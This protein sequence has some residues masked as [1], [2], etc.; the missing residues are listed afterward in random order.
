MS[1]EKTRDNY[2]T[3][4]FCDEC[5]EKMNVVSGD[6]PILSTDEYDLSWGDTCSNCGKTLEEE[7]KENKS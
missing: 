3:D 5:Y 1:A 6:N 4:V 2:P 7:I